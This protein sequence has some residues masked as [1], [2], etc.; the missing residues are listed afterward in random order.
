MWKPCCGSPARSSPHCWRHISRE[1]AALQQ[2]GPR[3]RSSEV[4]PPPFTS[5]N[6]ADKVADGFVPI[7]N[8]SELTAIQVLGM[9]AV[10]GW[11]AHVLTRR[12]MRPVAQALV[13]GL[14]VAFLT[15][16]SYMALSGHL[17]L[18]A[19]AIWLTITLADAL[20]QRISRRGKD[21]SAGR[22]A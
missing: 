3:S 1:L 5:G 19:F 2:C 16:T 4:S 15:V 18:L 17:A 6:I 9:A 14:V 8:S 11:L 12:G 13:T 10:I 20:H 7:D 21:S 22:A